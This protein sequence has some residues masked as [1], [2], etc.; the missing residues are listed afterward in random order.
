MLYL[1]RMSMYMYL[2]VKVETCA[3]MH[4]SPYLNPSNTHTHTHA[5]THAHT[6]THTHTQVFMSALVKDKYEKHLIMMEQNG[7]SRLT[8]WTVSYLFN[9][10]LYI[11]IA[12]EIAIVSFAFQIRLFTQVGVVC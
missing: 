12:I 9:Y 1:R 8:Y 2:H 11:P 7:L 5:R 3:S 10:L 6:H 4:A